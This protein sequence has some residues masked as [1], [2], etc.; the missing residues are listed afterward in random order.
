M[1][2]IK[3]EAIVDPEIEWETKWRFTVEPELYEKFKTFVMRLGDDLYERYSGL[4]MI[5]VQAEYDEEDDWGWAFLD[6]KEG[7]AVSFINGNTV[8]FILQNVPDDEF[9]R[10]DPKHPEWSEP[11]PMQWLKVARMF[12]CVMECEHPDRLA[13]S[14]PFE[15][16]DW[17]RAHAAVH[18]N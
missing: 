1:N 6:N 16:M 12:K 5:P 9:D 17:R 13:I 2:S 7:D 11:S 4:G 10:L 14:D 3:V 18:I 8:E 15:T